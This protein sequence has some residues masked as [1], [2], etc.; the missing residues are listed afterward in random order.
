MGVKALIARGG[1]LARAAPPA[2]D[3]NPQATHDD[4]R[5]ARE[6]LPGKTGGPEGANAD[7]TLVPLETGVKFTLLAYGPGLCRFR[8]L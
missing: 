6:L 2:L 8:R 1:V 7:L 3:Q 4:P 5:P